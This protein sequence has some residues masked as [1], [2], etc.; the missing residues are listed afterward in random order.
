MEKREATKKR[1]LS[2]HVRFFAIIYKLYIVIVYLANSVM[3]RAKVPKGHKEGFIYMPA[4]LA[5]NPR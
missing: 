4:I 3:E 2:K 1:E 5:K